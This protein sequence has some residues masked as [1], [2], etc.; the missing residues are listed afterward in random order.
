MLI[1]NTQHYIYIPSKFVGFQGYD[2][3]MMSTHCI[4]TNINIKT[5]H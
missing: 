1:I 2:V 3:S 5:Y 4:L